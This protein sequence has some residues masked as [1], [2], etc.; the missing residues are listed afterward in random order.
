MNDTG[1]MSIDGLIKALSSDADADDENI[2]IVTFP[3]AKLQQ[4]V[5]KCLGCSKEF[6]SSQINAS[7]SLCLCS[8]CNASVKTKNFSDIDEEDANEEDANESDDEHSGERAPPNHQSIYAQGEIPDYTGFSTAKDLAEHFSAAKIAH[9]CNT[10][11]LKVGNMV[12]EFTEL[13]SEESYSITGNACFWRMINDPYK[14]EKVLIMYGYDLYEAYLVGDKV[15][16]CYCMIMDE[17]G[18]PSGQILFKLGRTRC[19]KPRV[20]AFI[21]DIRE[22]R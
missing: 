3:A 17:D 4:C 6:D 1:A 9:D 11:G 10:V 20:D 21:Y 5:L 19:S 7:I 14:R 18:F 12:L 8:H 13:R 2:G 22:N 16:V 15:F